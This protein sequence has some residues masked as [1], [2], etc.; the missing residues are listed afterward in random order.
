[1]SDD[2]NERTE[3][4]IDL[5]HGV[6]WPQ[7]GHTL[8]LTYGHGPVVINTDRGPWY[9]QSVADKAWMAAQERADVDDDPTPRPVVYQRV[10]T[11]ASTAYPSQPGD[12]IVA[13]V[14]DPLSEDAKPPL[15]EVV[16][17]HAGEPT[18]ARWQNVAMG[19]WY[20]DDELHDVRPGPIGNIAELSWRTLA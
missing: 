5:G 4:G 18:G 8:T 10:I 13:R 17:V 14:E 19:T 9:M 1:V 6:A 20:E 15:I 12:V 3:Y 2:L 16:L 11:R 7:D